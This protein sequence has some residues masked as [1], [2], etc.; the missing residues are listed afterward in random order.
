MAH[1]ATKKELPPVIL[2]TMDLT[3]SGLTANRLPVNAFTMFAFK[4]F[5]NLSIF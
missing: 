5:S 1:E 4:F 2:L 3:F